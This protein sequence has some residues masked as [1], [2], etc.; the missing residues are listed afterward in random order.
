MFIRALHT[1]Q[2]AVLMAERGMITPGR[3]LARCMLEVIFLLVAISKDKA[4]ASKELGE[5]NG[6]A[7]YI[8]T[9]SNIFNT[10]LSAS[11]CVNPP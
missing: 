4:F 6:D 11:I 3:M 2:G 5:D 10:K 7:L 9:F 1:F 8:F